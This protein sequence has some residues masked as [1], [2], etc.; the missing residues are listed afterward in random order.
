[1]DGVTFGKRGLPKTYS[2]EKLGKKQG[3]LILYIELYIPKKKVVR[4][5]D[6]SLHHSP[7]WYPLP[8]HPGRAGGLGGHGT[9]VH[10]LK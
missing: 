4:E 1:M 9:I 2:K 10:L 8:E 6:I 5:K 7:V 3:N